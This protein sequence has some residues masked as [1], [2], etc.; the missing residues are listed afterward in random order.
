M[1]IYSM[2]Q[3]TSV[4]EGIYQIKSTRMDDPPYLMINVGDIHGSP[5]HL[6][7]LRQTRPT[8]HPALPLAISVLLLVGNTKMCQQRTKM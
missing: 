5:Y 2:E 4:K 6:L 1:I 3:H 8:V 7:S